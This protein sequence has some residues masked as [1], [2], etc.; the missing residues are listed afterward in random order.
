MEDRRSGVILNITSVAGILG[1]PGS[2]E[3]SAAKGASSR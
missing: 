1:L 2:I 3:Y